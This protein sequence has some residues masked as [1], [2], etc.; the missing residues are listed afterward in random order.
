MM[1]D[2]QS[3]HAWAQEIAAGNWIGDDVFYQ[4]PLYPYFFANRLHC[5]QRRTDGRANDTGGHRLARVRMPGVWRL[6]DVLETRR[7]QHSREAVR[8]TS[9]SAE[10]KSRLDAALAARQ[11]PTSLV[12]CRNPTTGLCN[13][14]GR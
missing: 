13:E 6:T 14:S 11:C 7:I 3:Y 9:D 4:A 10:L 1:G 5:L 2:A 8:L 12:D